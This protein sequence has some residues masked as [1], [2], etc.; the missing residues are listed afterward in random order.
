MKDIYLVKIVNGQPV[1]PPFQAEDGRVQLHYDFDKNGFPKKGGWTLIG[2]EEK[3]Q[4]IV[5]VEAPEA[6]HTAMK[7]AAKEAYQQVTKEVEATVCE[8]QKLPVTKYQELIKTPWAADLVK[9]VE[10]TK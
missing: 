4:A 5:M 6:T 3:G 7:A 1:L 2:P 10:I 8:A 9:A